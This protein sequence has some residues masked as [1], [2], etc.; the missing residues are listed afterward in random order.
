MAA[1]GKKTVAPYS[2]E[3]RRRG[4]RRQSVRLRLVRKL[5]DYLDGIDL[6]AYNVGDVFDLP[7][8]HAELL[9]IEG[10]A[11]PWIASPVG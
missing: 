5:A 10:W 6:T 1:G 3:E 2:G 4:E 11:L 9:I 7:H 8:R